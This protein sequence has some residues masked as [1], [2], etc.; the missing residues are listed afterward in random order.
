MKIEEFS[1]RRDLVDKIGRAK[2]MAGGSPVIIDLGAGQGELEVYPASLR[3]NP[4]GGVF[5]A[6]KYNLR[7]AL[8]ILAGESLKI[9][10]EYDGRIIARYS[11]FVIKKCRWSRTIARKI[12]DTFP[13]C[14]PGTG[15]NGQNWEKSLAFGDVLGM[16][17]RAQL[18]AFSGKAG[19][20]FSRQCIHELRDL[21]I[22]P[23]D[24]IDVIT[25]TVF[26][27]GLQTGYAAEACH[28]TSEEDVQVMLDAGYTRFSVEPDQTDL[29]AC[30]EK[31]KHEL[32][33]HMFEVPWIALR[34][35]FELMLHRYKGHRIEISAI[36]TSGHPYEEDEPL[37]VIPTESEVLAAIAMFADIILTMEAIEAVFE[38]EGVRD[39]I[40][41]DLSFNRS[42]EVLTPF[43]HYF[44]MNELH[45]HDVQ[46]DFL[47]PGRPDKNQWKLANHTNV[48]GLSGDIRFFSDSPP[49]G[50][51]LTQHGIVPDIGYTTALE[52]M[53]EKDPELF[54]I[55]WDSSRNVFEDAKK[56]SH[57]SLEIHRIPGSSEYQDPELMQ[58]LQ[59][60]QAEEFVK[61]TMSNVLSLKDEHGKR[62]LRQSLMDFLNEH[63][64]L[65]IARLASKYQYWVDT[66]FA[67]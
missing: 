9:M 11:D 57:I 30:R 20:A 34:D 51:G 29:F 41:V 54:R 13:E 15:D 6:G 66:F 16:A 40:C 31:T 64:D 21:D 5:I 61:L 42:G 48:K 32:L 3:S 8:F 50:S 37:V 22:H 56:G 7:K 10:E 1:N 26:Q 12:R 49:A 25:F 63:E 43:E 14:A 19:L 33:N 45:R 18:R 24:V 47:G 23:E 28:L 62:Y 58:L 27:E 2:Q 67:D 53:I 60:D 39:K 59:G 17:G 52:C 44:L 46:P 38:K 65:Y 36:D 55:M 4:K 35:K